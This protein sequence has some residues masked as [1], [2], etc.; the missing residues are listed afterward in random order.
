MSL[1]K[2]VIFNMYHPISHIINPYL[3]FYLK[4]NHSNYFFSEPSLDMFI[5]QD[6][7]IPYSEVSTIPET[8][9]DTSLQSMS[10][11]YR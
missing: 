5:V 8:Q 1:V 6:D 9:L 3:L 2:F 11:L 4:T 10:N 7:D